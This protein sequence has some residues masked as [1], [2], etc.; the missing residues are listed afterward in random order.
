MAGCGWRRPLAH[1][2]APLV[3]SRKVNSHL[4]SSGGGTIIVP[5]LFVHPW[6]VDGCVS[7]AFA[8]VAALH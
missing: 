3:N 6:S 1:H 4:C 7:L 5:E 2:S 8:T